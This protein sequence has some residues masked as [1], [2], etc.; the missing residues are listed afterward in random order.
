MVVQVRDLRVKGTQDFIDMSLFTSAVQTMAHHCQLYQFKEIA[1]PIIEHLDLFKRSLGLHTDVVSKEM[2]VIQPRDEKDD[3]I[4]LRPEATAPTLR[5]F[6][7]EGIQSMPWKVFS[8][9]PMFRYE[10]PQKGRFRQFHQFNIEILGA[11]SILHD[12]ELISMLDKLFTN[13]FGI[14]ECALAV[15]FLG[16]ADD[17][18]NFNIQLKAFLAQHKNELCET[19]QQRAESNVLRIFDCKN[20][21][22]QQL[23]RMAPHTIDHL[24]ADCQAEWNVLLK[25]LSM[26]S[27]SYTVL[28]SL[29]RGLDYYTKTVFEFSSTLLGA[30]CALGGGGRYDHLAQTLGYK[31]AVP[32]CGCGIG[33]ER[34]LAVLEKTG[35][36]IPSQGPQPLVAVLPIDKPQQTLALLA[37]DELRSQEIRT[38]IMLDE[39]SLKSM[40]RKAGKLE[41]T[42]AIMIGEDEQKKGIVRLRAMADGSELEVPLVGLAAYIKNTYTNFK[43]Q[44]VYSN[45]GEI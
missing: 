2:F 36:T 43:E 25:N 29:V 21:A 3:L 24:C 38:V 22:C 5:A 33:I 12:V 18:K 6:M 30:Q 10:R 1:T 42:H 17:R 27:V 44:N 35:Y 45:P 8:Y 9:G 13:V 32:A 23:Y 11:P 34:L 26:L 19:C 20:E 37:A 15:N 39:T 4:C 16:C 31:Q 40:L 41:V 14:T 7:D 28:P